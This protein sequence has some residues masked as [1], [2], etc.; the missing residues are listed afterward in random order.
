MKAKEVRAFKCA[1]CQRLRS[2]KERA[3]KCCTC[4]CGKKTVSPHMDACMSCTRRNA[5][6]R[7][8]VDVKRAKETLAV[9]EQRVI[10][11]QAELEPTR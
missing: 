3:E 9:R 7:A 5:L 11:L 4:R 10:Q 1:A 6:R 8:R 2:T